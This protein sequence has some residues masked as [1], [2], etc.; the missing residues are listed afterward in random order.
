MLARRPFSGRPCTLSLG[1]DAWPD[2]VEDQRAEI[3]EAF[4]LTLRRLG[5]RSLAVSKVKVAIAMLGFMPKK[6]EIQKM[7]QDRDDD[8]VRR[9]HGRRRYVGG[10]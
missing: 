9:A 6:E 5:S 7:I 8:G 4:D 2:L 1:C 10:E 3:K